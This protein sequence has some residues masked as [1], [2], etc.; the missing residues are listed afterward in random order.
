MNL[1]VVLPFLSTTAINILII[2][3]PSIDLIIDV[4][5]TSSCTGC[6]F[7]GNTI[8]ATISYGVSMVELDVSNIAIAKSVTDG[9]VLLDV[10]L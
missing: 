2:T 6:S 8:T 3:Y 5:G 4:G 9:P 10:K 1:I 7:A